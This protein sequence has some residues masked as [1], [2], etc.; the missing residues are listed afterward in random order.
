MICGNQRALKE[1]L[2]GTGFR[3]ALDACDSISDDGCVGPLAER[4]RDT[5]T[6]VRRHWVVVSES[7]PSG[8]AEACERTAFT[9]SRAPRYGSNPRALLMWLTTDG[10]QVAV[11]PGIK[12]TVAIGKGAHSRMVRSMS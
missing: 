1:Q 12:P 2:R 6:S 11:G 7:V 5:R 8:R 10:V 3:Q 4:Q 9:A